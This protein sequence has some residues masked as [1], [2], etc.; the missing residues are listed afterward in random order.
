MW[1]NRW[2]RLEPARRVFQHGES[3]KDGLL[4]PRR[5]SEE[6]RQKNNARVRAYYWAN[7]DKATAK[8]RAYHAAHR[9]RENGQSRAYRATHKKEGR[10]YMRGWRAANPELVHATERR[11]RARRLTLPCTATAEHEK[12]IKVAYKGRCAYCGRKPTKR[13]PLTI[14][15]VI[16]I[17]KNGGHVPGNL[18]PACQSC[19]CRKNDREAPSIPPVR[20]LL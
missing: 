16:P 2:S 7:R 14:D 3:V 18:V 15:H 6:Q 9:D 13:N 4:M 5:T 10:I 8:S 19:N 12:A 11:R 17:A 20:L 1:Y